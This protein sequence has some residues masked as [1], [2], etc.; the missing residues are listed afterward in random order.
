MLYGWFTRIMN[1]PKKVN[2]VALKYAF[3][4]DG[5]KSREKIVK[6]P[7]FFIAFMI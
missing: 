2:A 6:T 3:D 4:F 5:V 7:L 1:R